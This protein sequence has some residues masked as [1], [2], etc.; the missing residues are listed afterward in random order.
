ME[1]S[2][3]LTTENRESTIREV[4]QKFHKLGPGCKGTGGEVRMNRMGPYTFEEYIEE[5]RKFH[6]Y[7]APGVI[8][9]G[10]M[11]ERAK[12]E[13]PSGILYNAV[14]ETPACLPDAIQLLTPCTIGNGWLS[15][16]H[17]GR[18]ALALYDKT[19]G[20]GVRVSL[21]HDRMEEF[22]ELAAWFFKRRPREQ[23]K[24][25]ALMGEIRGASP[26]I[27]RANPV[28]VNAGQ[29]RRAKKGAIIRCPSCGESYPSELGA[30]CPGCQGKSPYL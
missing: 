10:Y 15:I 27:L 5:V 14:S 22:P 8:L 28:K 9:G 2:F 11:V 1:K 4:V 19:N 13:M 3:R 20:E 17:L 26:L 23:C 12:S 24:D 30:L 6:S 18:F 16:L 25:D 29:L 7:P 21:D